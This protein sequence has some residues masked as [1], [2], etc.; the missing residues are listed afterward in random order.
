MIVTA[1]SLVDRLLPPG[2]SR[3]VLTNGETWQLVDRVVRLGNGR[4]GIWIGIALY[5]MPP[6][7]EVETRLTARRVVSYRLHR[8]P[9][10]KAKLLGWEYSHDHAD[11]Y[12]IKSVVLEPGVTQVVRPDGSV[13]YLR[14]YDGSVWVRPIE[15]PYPV[16]E[17]TAK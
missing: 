14:R 6:N 12:Q 8:Q 9:A 15:E 10:G 5:E 2:F 7:E 3:E 4:V 13:E 17:E 16:E 11:W 1:L